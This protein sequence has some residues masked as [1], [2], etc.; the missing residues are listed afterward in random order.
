MDYFFT[1]KFSDGIVG[2]YQVFASSLES[3][4]NLALR[5][6][7]C[8]AVEN[9]VSIVD[10]RF[11]GVDDFVPY[12]RMSKKAKKAYNDKKR[13]TWGAVNPVTRKSANPRAYDRNKAKAAARKRC[14]EWA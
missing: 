4:R 14:A 13:G 6:A 9:D 12:E 10:V 3:A 1:A 8:D 5:Q 7:E 2:S 11:K